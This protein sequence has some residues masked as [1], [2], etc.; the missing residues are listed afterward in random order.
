VA[1]GRNRAASAGAPA[2]LLGV[3]RPVVAGVTRD[4]SGLTRIC[5]VQPLTLC[6][7]DI[8]N[9][10]EVEGMGIIGLLVVLILIVLLL[11]LL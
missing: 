10:R 8:T 3:R 11:R 4:K 2:H 7:P 5:N 1:S 9:S 6:W